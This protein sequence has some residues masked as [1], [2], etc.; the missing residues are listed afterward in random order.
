M[1]T[2]NIYCHTINNKKYIGYTE[3]NINV[4]LDEHIQDSRN[5]SDTYFHRAI[6]KYGENTII[7][8]KLD[9]CSTQSD[10][11]SKEIYYIDLLDTFSYG[12]NMTRGGDGGNTKER[13]SKKQ[14]IEWGK[15]RSKLSAGMNN[16][17]AR[18]DITAIDIINT[19][20]N[21]IHENFKYGSYLLRNEIDS[22][23]KS[24]LSISSRLISNRG[25]KN[26]TDLIN[27]VNATLTATEQVK[28][29]PHYRSPTQKSLLSIQSSKWRWITDG[30]TNIRI[31]SSSINEYLLEN[32]NWRIGRTIN[33]E[34]N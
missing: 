32:T 14:L 25:I 6:R 19:I 29:N 28:Y 4:R 30:Y 15:N 24:E 5:G 16:G 7:T 9:E 11:K 1:K 23:L 31:D 33:H 2:Y 34:N 27:L 17:N 8:E 13:Y 12:Y 22:V 26:H 21:Y 3:K 10:A 18:P 20:V